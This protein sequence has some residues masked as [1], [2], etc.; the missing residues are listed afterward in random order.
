M[1][2]GKR[3]NGV[4]TAVGVWGNAFGVSR[5]RIVCGKCENGVWNGLG[6][7]EVA[8]GIVCEPHGW[9]LR[10]V[11]LVREV[12]GSNEE[13]SVIMREQWEWGVQNVRMV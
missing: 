10:V 8:M 11:T 1:E 5:V 12:C 4:R 3:E 9:G 2:C 6:R 13:G 7:V